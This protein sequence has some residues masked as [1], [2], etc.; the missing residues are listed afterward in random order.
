MGGE[1]EMRTRLTWAA[2]LSIVM[3]PVLAIGWLDPL[4][5]LPLVIVGIG[6]GVAVRLLSK[7][8]I[9]RFTWIS[10]VAVA[11]LMTITI[12][13]VAIGGAILAAQPVGDTG[14]NPTLAFPIAAVLLWVSRLADLVMVVG[15]VLYS[16]RIFQAR[17]A[18]NTASQP[19]TP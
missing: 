10:F 8:P 12:V 6:F 1:A 3:I 4:E 17:R 2:V 11:T 15:L 13:A 19:T 5:G 14:V 7:V 18:L 9:P 16:V